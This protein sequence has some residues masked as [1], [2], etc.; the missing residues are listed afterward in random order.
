M[1][2]PIRSS[3]KRYTEREYDYA[4]STGTPVLA[5]LHA[6]PD[7][8]PKRN[9][10]PTDDG[11]AKLDEFREK[12]SKRMCKLWQTPQELGSAVSRSLVKAIRSSPAK[13]WVRADMAMTPEQLAELEQLRREVME[14]EAD[15]ATISDTPPPGT[16]E[17]T[18]GDD[19]TEIAF[20]ANASERGYVFE[21]QPFS[22]SVQLSWDRIF[23]AIGPAM[24]DEAA[25]GVLRKMLANLVEEEVKSSASLEDLRKKGLV[26]FDDW[27]VEQDSWDKVKVQ[28]VAL[29]LIDKGKKRRG[30][31]DKATYWALTPYGE[32]YVMRLKAERRPV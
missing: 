5:F 17:F 15:Q 24:F 18:Q 20:L 4:V 14:L 32:R 28:F 21:K 22:G 11:T 6:D 26:V 25:E 8:L 3:P 19:V 13:G 7:G 23:A 31:N 10:E 29:K 12:V 30:V 27:T 16:E 2:P 1:T 9:T